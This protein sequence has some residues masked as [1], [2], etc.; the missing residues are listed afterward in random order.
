MQEGKNKMTIMMLINN[1]L[2]KDLKKNQSNHKQREMIKKNK[3]RLM[4]RW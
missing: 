4:K 3:I 2:I 1:K